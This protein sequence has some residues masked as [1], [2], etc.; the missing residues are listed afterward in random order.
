MTLHAGAICVSTF[1]IAILE[2]CLPIWLM[3]SMSPP[4]WQL[5]KKYLEYLNEDFKTK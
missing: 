2:P 1:A 5:G 4:R 3:E